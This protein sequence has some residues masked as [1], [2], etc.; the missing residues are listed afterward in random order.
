MRAGEDPYFVH[1]YRINFDGSGLVPLTEAEGNHHVEYSD[2]GKF[3][4]DTWS[5]IDVPPTMALYRVEDN[6]QLMV[7]EKVDAQKLLAAG[8]HAPE[9][10]TAK[11]RDGTTDIWFGPILPKGVAEANWA[12]TIPG[13]GWNMLFRLYG[14]L[15]PW[16]DKTWQPGEFELVK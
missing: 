8:W 2:D 15:G 9:V 6:K 7:L 13:K 5:K 1:A 11:G 4:I 3:Y 12:Q 10:F 14:P 16:F